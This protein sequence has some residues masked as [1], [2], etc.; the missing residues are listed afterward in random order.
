MRFGRLRTDE[1]ERTPRLHGVIRRIRCADRRG[2]KL[3]R[4]DSNAPLIHFMRPV[5]VH[6]KHTEATRVRGITE[7]TYQVVADAWYSHSAAI[8]ALWL[9]ITV[10]THQLFGAADD[11]CGRLMHAD[12]GRDVKM[13]KLDHRA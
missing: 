3:T 12:D 1:A 9:A 2:R 8:S 10:K 4:H 6:S 7:S 13:P 5:R 11:P